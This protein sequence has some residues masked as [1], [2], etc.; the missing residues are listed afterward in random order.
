MRL[1]LGLLA[2]LCAFATLI[3]VSLLSYSDASRLVSLPLLFIVLLTFAT[4]KTDV[5][6][7]ALLAGFLLDLFSPLPFGVHAVSLS[8]VAVVSRA[9][10]DHFF[11][12]RSVYAMMLLV[13]LS[14]FLYSALWFGS[15]A[16]LHALHLSLFSVSLTLLTP[17]A[18]LGNVVLAVLVLYVGLLF[19]RILGRQFFTRS[20]LTSRRSP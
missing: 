5:S 19:R 7:F 11:T 10:V 4:R 6:W 18:L 17:W 14:T 9:L 20:S 13:A 12:N 16:A 8:I 3:Q 15:A 2:F 1:Q